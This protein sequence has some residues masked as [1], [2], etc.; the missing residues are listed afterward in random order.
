MT[1]SLPRK[2]LLMGATGFLGSKIQRQL[3]QYPAFSLR[4]M[5]RRG[6]PANVS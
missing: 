4:A 6:A 1:I 3:E 2:I 5:S